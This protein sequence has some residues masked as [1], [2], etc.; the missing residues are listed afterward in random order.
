MQNMLELQCLVLEKVSDNSNLFKKELEKSVKWLNNNDLLE[1]KRRLLSKYNTKHIDL[2][3][4]VLGGI[5]LA[6]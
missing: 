2:I 1:L 5:P 4:D 3:N 6:S